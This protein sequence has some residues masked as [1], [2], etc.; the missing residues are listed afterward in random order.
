MMGTM[1]IDHNDFEKLV[2]KIIAIDLQS[3]YVIIGELEDIDHR[4]LILKEVDVHDLRDSKTT[5]ERYLVESKKYGVRVNRNRVYVSHNEVVSFS[6][7]EDIL[8]S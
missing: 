5:R 7:L 4:Y 1:T 3:L 6:L 2:G 8:D